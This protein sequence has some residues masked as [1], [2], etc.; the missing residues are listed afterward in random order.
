MVIKENSWIGIN[1][2]D[3][4]VHDPSCDKII[5]VMMFLVFVPYIHT[6]LSS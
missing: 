6:P 1:Q 3:M 5:M 4:V 2:E